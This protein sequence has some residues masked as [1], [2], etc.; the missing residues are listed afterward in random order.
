MLRKAFSDF[1]SVL[2]HPLQL[3]VQKIAWKF[4]IHYLLFTKGDNKHDPCMYN[5]PKA[6][7]RVLMFKVIRLYIQVTGC[8]K[9][10]TIADDL[11][12]GF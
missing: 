5:T 8:K 10:S 11:G 3:V 2:R 1:P 6:S 9:I 12:F 4:S 7:R